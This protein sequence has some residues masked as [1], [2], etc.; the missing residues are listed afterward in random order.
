M[1]GL[2]S[3]GMGACAGVRTD[4]V[5]VGALHPRDEEGAYV[6]V[7]NNTHKD[8]QRITLDCRFQLANGRITARDVEIAPVPAGQRFE[9]R[10]DAAGMVRNAKRADCL[11]RQWDHGMPLGVSSNGF[12]RS[13]TMIKTRP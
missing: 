6:V 8:F 10:P 12:V 5:S 9:I 2:A 3:F 11:P 1:I 13:Q 4:F 7:I